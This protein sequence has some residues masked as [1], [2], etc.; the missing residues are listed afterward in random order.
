MKTSINVFKNN[1]QG[2]VRV[3][4]DLDLSASSSEI[5]N[6]RGF[7]PK[8]KKRKNHALKRRKPTRWSKEKLDELLN[9]LYRKG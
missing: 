1:S 6:R 7:H 3:D 4:K 9:L 8:P 2:N 5:E